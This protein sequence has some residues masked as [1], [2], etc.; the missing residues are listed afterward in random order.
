MYDDIIKRG[1][2]YNPASNHYHLGSTV[3]C[4]RCQRSNLSVCVGINN[5]DLCLSCV[6]ELTD[7]I[8]LKTPTCY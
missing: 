3:M 1:T 8:I 7:N 5:R 4:D 6:Q 2:Y